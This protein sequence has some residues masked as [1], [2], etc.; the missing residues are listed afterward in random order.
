MNRLT[1][2]AIEVE[3]AV[4]EYFN[5]RQN[6]IVPNVAWGMNFNYELDLLVITRARY[7]YEVEIKIS[8]HDL[9][10]DVQKKHHH[11]SPK[12]KRLYFAIPEFLLQEQRHIPGNAGILVIKPT[13]EG[14]WRVHEE[15]KPKSKSSYE[16]TDAEILTAERLG[17]L[18]VFPLKKQIVKL[19]L[20]YLG[21][22]KSKK[23]NQRH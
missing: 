16:F 20:E 14:G 3:I 18:R 13:R 2:S 1:P 15:R 19:A 21:K 8:R 7:G 12:I 17:R 6:T 22:K 9:M 5:P 10:R 11:D 4:A 23:Q